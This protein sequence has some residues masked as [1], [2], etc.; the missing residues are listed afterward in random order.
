MQIKLCTINNNY[1]KINMRAGIIDRFIIGPVIL[2]PRLNGINYLDH[3]VNLPRL[4][5]E[6]PLAIRQN[7][8]FMHAGASRHFTLN[9]RNHLKENFEIDGSTKETMLL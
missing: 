6:L 9:V 3:L 2:P 7:M 4:F 8:W 1:F 5:D